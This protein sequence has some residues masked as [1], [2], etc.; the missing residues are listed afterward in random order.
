MYRFAAFASSVLLMAFQTAPPILPTRLA[1]LADDVQA[2]RS[3]DFYALKAEG[4]DL[5]ALGES[6]N[7]WLRIRTGSAPD[8]TGGRCLNEA[9]AELSAGITA[10]RDA[11]DAATFAADSIAA[12]DAIAKWQAFSDALVAG[13]AATEP[14]FKWVSGR[15]RQADEATDPRVRELLQRTAHDQLHRHAFS[16]GDQV[17]G[18]LSPGVKNRVHGFLSRRLC[19]IDSSN[20]AWLKAD[21]ATNGW[22]LVSTAGEGASGSAW[23]M[24]QHADRDRPFQRDVLA[25]LEPLIATG[26]TSASNYAYLYDRV[27]V[28]EHRPQRYGTQGHCIAANRWA[29]DELEDPAAVE[30]LRAQ[31]DIGTLV[32]YQAHMHQYCADFTG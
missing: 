22:Y 27:A 10:A 29:P 13:L 19:E 18:V 16:G 21:V 2:A 17:W 23:L 3:F 12:Q 7:E 26:E 1:S 20:T 11:P 30:T 14:P 4:V 31:V 24:A 28:G 15:Y 32:E 25:M 9:E 8:W 6:A 5:A